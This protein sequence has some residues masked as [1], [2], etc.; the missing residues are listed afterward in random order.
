[1]T[2]V[3][4]LRNA[5][6]C[7]TLWNSCMCSL[8]IPRTR[9]V[10]TLNA[11]CIVDRNSNWRIFFYFPRHT[12]VTNKI[13]I[14]ELI[15]VHGSVVFIIVVHATAENACRRRGGRLRAGRSLSFLKL[16][17]ISTQSVDCRLDATS[18]NFQVFRIRV[19]GLLGKKFRNYNPVRKMNTG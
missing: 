19:N 8:A 15:P 16:F 17:D 10:A 3:I 12:M 5:C 11:I 1:M 4:L 13:S 6:Q 7:R 9:S 2:R 14:V 18:S